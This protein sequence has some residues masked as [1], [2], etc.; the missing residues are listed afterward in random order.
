MRIEDNS[1][2]GLGSSQLERAKATNTAAQTGASKAAQK[3]GGSA[4]DRV[5][6]SNLAESLNQLD[7]TSPQREERLKQLSAAVRAGT[8]EPNAE[9]ISSAMIDEALG[10]SGPVGG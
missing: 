10:Q 4:S 3:G 8:Y 9:M 6:L 7:A 2:A 5:N 1:N